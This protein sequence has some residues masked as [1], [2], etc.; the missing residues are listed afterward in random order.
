MNLGNKN[1]FETN[2]K[3]LAAGILQQA[4]RDLRRFHDATGPLEQELYLDAYSWVIS[5]DCSWPFSFLNV[6]HLLNLTPEVVRLEVLGDAPAGFFTYWSRRCQRAGRSIKSF[7][8]HAF[9]PR[10]STRAVDPVPLTH[11]PIT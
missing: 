9:T 7:L 8:N 1:T 6:C 4:A 2:Q 3:T 11:L 5:H 10:R